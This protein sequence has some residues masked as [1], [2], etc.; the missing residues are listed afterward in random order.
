M[1]NYSKIN[2]KERELLEEWKRE[3][4]SNKECARRLRRS[5][6]TIGREL[7]RNGVMTSCGRIYLASY[8]QG[9]ADKRQ[10]K[11]WEVKHPLKNKKVFRYVIRQLMRGW[12]PEQIAG[13]LKYCYPDDPSW[14]ICYETIYQFIYSAEQKHRKWWEYLETRTEKKTKKGRKK[15]SSQSYT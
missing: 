10:K 6:S 3:G 11:A 4:L 12:S 15:S 9:K 5:P 8:A 1:N 13:R 2:R 14:H 7:E